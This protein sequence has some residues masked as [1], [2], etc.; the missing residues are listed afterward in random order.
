LADPWSKQWDQPQNRSFVHLDN[1]EDAYIEQLLWY[2]QEL[3]QDD[4]VVCATI[5]TAGPSGW[6]SF[7]MYEGVSIKLAKQL[8]GLE[9]QGGDMERRIFDA[10]GQ[11]QTEAWLLSKYG[12]IDTTAEAGAE[13]GI[14]ELRER[15]DAPSTLVVT[16]KDEGG[17]PVPNVSVAFS[18]PDGTVHGMTDNM[19]NVGFGMGGGAYYDPDQGQQGPHWINAGGVEV[20]GLGMRI[21]TNQDHVDVVLIESE[22]QPPDPPDPPEPPDECC[23]EIIRL[24][25]QIIELL[26]V[27][28][29]K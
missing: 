1:D 9:P 23:E 16:V 28:A 4:Y 13:Y 25:N 22:P 26:E 24:M 19:G 8:A 18:W 10:Q 20:R 5:F 21:G 11:Q 2:E 27:I 14:V 7:E 15:I 29:A 12:Q 17:N 6:D 3:R